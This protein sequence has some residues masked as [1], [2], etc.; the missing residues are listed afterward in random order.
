M[1]AAGVFLMSNTLEIG[2]SERQFLALVEAL[3]R[4]RF[5]VRP[6]CLRRIGPLVERVG[7]IPE[8][9]VGGSLFRIQAQ[10][11]R[12]KMAHF[13]RA[14]RI[15]V[16]HSF[17]FYTNLMLIPT[18]RL[19]GV[20]VVIG[21]HRQLGDLLTRTQFGAQTFVFRFC[22]CVVCNSR[23]AADRLRH[24]GLPSSKVQIISNGLPDHIFLESEPAFP[25]SQGTVRIGMIARMNDPVK[26][27]PAFLKAASRLTTEFS[28]L[29]ILLIGDGPL[30]PEY[31][32]LAA[33]L[34]L[35]E[36]V[37]FAGE[38]HDIPAVLASMD[39][40]VSP[41]SS[42][43]LSNV[44][45]ESMAAG[46]SVVAT[47]VGG[48]PELISDQKT[49]LLVPPGNEDALV[50]ALGRLLRDPALRM[51]YAHNAKEFARAHFPM[52]VVSRRY[53]Q[54]YEDLL[55]QKRGSAGR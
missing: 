10:R 54:L 25:R 49:G 5:D 13:L 39:I 37:T 40:S 32:R 45:M 52:T 9:P 27:Y 6:A 42:E 1:P 26:N 17:D 28:N 7:E 30:R 16:A 34:G 24:A 47:N 46:V 3:D 8:F 18:A 50:A 48:N 4:S 31:E 15:A 12:L 36:R 21:S 53:E 41:S 55:E 20:K 35:G 44:I 11:T 38:R 43:S 23:A 51:K 33:E 2:G 22:D 14:H 19:A 29:D